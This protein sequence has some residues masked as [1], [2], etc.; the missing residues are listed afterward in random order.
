M[1]MK[2]IDINVKGM[3]CPS[4]EA[5]LTESLSEIDGVKSVK[6]SHETGI[7]KVEYDDRSVK[8]PDLKKIIVKEGYKV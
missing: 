5:I 4:C 6:A 7:V 1:K 8:V 3:H 2:T